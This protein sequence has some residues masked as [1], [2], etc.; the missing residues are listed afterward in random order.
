MQNGR[1]ICQAVNLATAV[2]L[3]AVHSTP[4]TRIADMITIQ[5]EG[6]AEAQAL[7]K[8]LEKIGG[9]KAMVQYEGRTRSD[10][11][12]SNAEV[13]KGHQ[14]GIETRNHGKKVRD[15]I[16][17]GAELNDKMG[18]ALIKEIER[19]I[20]RE[21]RSGILKVR[22]SGKV[23]AGKAY[24]KTLKHGGTK[25]ITAKKKAAGI[26]ARAFKKIALMWKQNIS[27]LIRSQKD[28]DGAALDGLEPDY[29]KIKMAKHGRERPILVAT[30]ELL[31]S[32]TG[33]M[34][35]IRYK[36]QS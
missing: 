28:V 8:M 7:L 18:K 25:A 29:A 13:L 22:K 34:G 16:G 1:V 33:D 11:K 35:G 17:P 32:V 4:S 19:S 2:M 5:P 36:A 20:K 27:E 15:V 9:I 26:L 21:Q 24:M 12:T 6:L 3:D 14:E 10:G 30:G 23:V 31:D